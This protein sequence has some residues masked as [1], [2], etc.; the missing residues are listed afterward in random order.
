MNVN[1]TEVN[2]LD[3]KLL[4]RVDLTPLAPELV[5][6]DE[7]LV[8][9]AEQHNAD[10]AELKDRFSSLAE[11]R[12]FMAGAD[13]IH[14]DIRRRIHGHHLIMATWDLLASLHEL[15]DVRQGILRYM[16]SRLADRVSGLA[17]RRHQLLSAATTRIDNH[18]PLADL[19][20]QI[21]VRESAIRRLCAL[22]HSA[23]TDQQVV[24]ARWEEAR[25]L[26]HR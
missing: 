8:D 13:D 2:D 26:P 5:A 14:R 19:H 12:R 16:Q 23:G 15:L 10:L 6:G 24:T 7:E 4:A 18:E 1:W 22:R 3:A 21:A 25:G 20:D 17:R 11:E 9:L